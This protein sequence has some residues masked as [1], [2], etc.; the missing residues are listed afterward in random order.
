M[1]ES[2]TYL[3]VEVVVERNRT[4]SLLIVSLG[5]CKYHLDGGRAPFNHFV[6]KWVVCILQIRKLSFREEFQSSKARIGRQVCLEG[7]S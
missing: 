1:I 4:K 3:G 6:C 5:W 7:L 2:V